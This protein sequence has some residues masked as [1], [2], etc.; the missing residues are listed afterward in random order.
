MRA[1]PISPL[2]PSLLLGRRNSQADVG[3]TVRVKRSDPSCLLK[4]SAYAQPIPSTSSS[5]YRAS[6]PPTLGFALVWLEMLVA[7]LLDDE[8]PEASRSFAS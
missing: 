6:S 3:R 7:L 1:T 8:A 2:A 5:G 4:L